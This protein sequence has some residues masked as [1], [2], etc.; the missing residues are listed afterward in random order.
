METLNTTLNWLRTRLKATPTETP[1]LEQLKTQIE[2]A[3]EFD[4]LVSLPGWEKAM[5][6]LVDKMNGELFEGRK[7]PYNSAAQLQCTQRYYAMQ[8]AVSGLEGHILSIQGERD[9]IVNEWKER[10]NGGNNDLGN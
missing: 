1:T 4:R 10:I 2:L 5:R 7:Y 8:D 3:E 6:Y 9:R